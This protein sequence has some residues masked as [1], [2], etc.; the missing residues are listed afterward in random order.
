[1]IARFAWAQDPS[2][3]FAFVTLNSLLSMK[4]ERVGSR[5]GLTV[6]S[7]TKDEL[8]RQEEHFNKRVSNE[9]IS[10]HMYVEKGDFVLSGL[11][12]WLGSVDVSFVDKPICI[13]PDYKVFRLS[14]N[15]DPLFFRYMVRTHAFR[16]I[17]KEAA[18]ERASV[19]RKNFDRETFLANEIPLP[20]L[21]EQRHLAGTIC[22][23][24]R[25]V[26]MSS[27]RRRELIRQRDALASELL[28]GRLRV[29]DAGRIGVAAA[30]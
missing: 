2:H 4:R 16:M 20:P 24:E 22:E 29:P 27:E 7:V 10:R 17:L 19:V 26:E 9:D 8:I 13:S 18:V 25:L 28:T 12:F 23:V 15:L 30:G 6:F 21:S 11:N 14:E 3:R 5:T 1:M